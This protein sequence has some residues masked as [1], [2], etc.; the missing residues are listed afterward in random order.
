[1]SWFY[2]LPKAHASLY[3]ATAA[4]C[5][6]VR[7]S[8]RKAG[9]C[10]EL[11]V[12]DKPPWKSAPETPCGLGDS[13]GDKGD[14]HQES[15]APIRAELSARVRIPKYHS[16]NGSMAYWWSRRDWA[17]ASVL[18]TTARD[19]SNSEIVRSARRALANIKCCHVFWF[20]A[21]AYVFGDSGASLS[22]PHLVAHNCPAAFRAA[23][24]EA[25]DITRVKGL[26]LKDTAP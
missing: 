2:R 25:S 9:L 14:S 11:Q 24:N 5:P 7:D 22:F 1:V 15:G 21:A 6:V 23:A 20:Y 4:G 13:S 17:E 3:C 26:P 8:R 12:A 18:S 19:C 10:R 16:M